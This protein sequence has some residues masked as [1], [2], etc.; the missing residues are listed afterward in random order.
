MTEKQSHELVKTEPEEHILLLMTVVGEEIICKMISETESG[1]VIKDPYVVI[2]DERSGLSLIRRWS[3]LSSKDIFTINKA[4]IL[5]Y[6]VHIE[7]KIKE[8]YEGQIAYT[9]IDP[10]ER[11]K[12]LHAMHE[13]NFSTLH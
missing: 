1:I 5:S 9:A 2:Q 13:K 12:V 11:E 8:L 3:L 10:S 4:G 7:E 6:N